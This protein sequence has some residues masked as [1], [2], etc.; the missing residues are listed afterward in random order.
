MSTTLTSLL[1]IKPSETAVVV[2]DLQKGIVAGPTLPHN[3]HE[4][5][6]NAVKLTD[7]L[8]TKGGFIIIV[9]VA[10]SPDGKDAI[11]PKCDL[12]MSVADRPEDWADIVPELQLQANDHLITKKQWGAFYGTDLDLQLRRRKISTVIFSGIATSFGVE[13]TARNASELGYELI[14]AEDAMSGRTAEEHQHTIEKIFP[15]IGRVRSTLEI[16]DAINRNN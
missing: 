10:T 8:R 15:R 4:V 7:A 6:A 11:R 12:Q 1:D 5:I 3:S 16:M 14:F 13:S 9:R 2:I